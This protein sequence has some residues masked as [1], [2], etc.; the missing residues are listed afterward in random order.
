[1]HDADDVPELLS[2]MRIIVIN[3][4][5]DLALARA[6]ADVPFAILVHILGA[7][8]IRHPDQDALVRL[9]VHIATLGQ[10]CSGDVQ[11]RRQWIAAG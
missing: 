3:V 10:I 6:V 1:M 5:V 7:V 9:R 4:V 8:R 2:R 11:R